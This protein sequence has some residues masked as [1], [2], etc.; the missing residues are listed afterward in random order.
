MGSMGLASVEI[1]RANGAREEHEVGRHILLDWCRRMI[2]AE[3][4]ETV[5]L[6][7]GRVMLVD[8]MGHQRG[9]PK[10]EQ[11]TV[12]YRSVCRPGTAAVIVGDV[13]ICRDR[14]FA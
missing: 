7:D 9:L 4:I 10:N 13:A 12:L 3:T 2:G 1:L 8:D 14:D 6:R 5:N 11:A